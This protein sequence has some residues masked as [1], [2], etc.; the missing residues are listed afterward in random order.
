[1]CYRMLYVCMHSALSYNS[2]Q[3]IVYISCDWLELVTCLLTLYCYP[4]SFNFYIHLVIIYCLS[5]QQNSQWTED[6]R[7]ED[8]VQVAK[9]QFDI[10]KTKHLVKFLYKLQNI[11]F[12]VIFN[13]K[14]QFS[15]GNS[16]GGWRGN[17]TYEVTQ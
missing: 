16:I 6:I 8:F 1:M 4:T 12:R 17:A 5:I 10:L 11:K 9:Y 2:S 14:Y 7:T 13:N 3:Y 15:F